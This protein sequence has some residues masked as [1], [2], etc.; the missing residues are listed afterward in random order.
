M[1]VLLGVYW[2]STHALS[3]AAFYDYLSIYR[4]SILNKGRAA[5]HLGG[6]HDNA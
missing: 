3:V 6:V 2:V 1:V 5:V 4:C